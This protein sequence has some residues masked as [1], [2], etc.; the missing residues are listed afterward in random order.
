MEIQILEFWLL[1]LAT[2]IVF[3]VWKKNSTIL[4][5]TSLFLLGFGYVLTFDG[6]D[7]VNGIVPSTGEFTF[8]KILPVNDALLT[9]FA[10]GTIPVAFALFFFSLH[11]TIIELLAR[12]KDKATI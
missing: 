7:I 2:G 3:S 10:I 1:L 8:V 4:M 6:I 12:Y 9:F 5:I 11:V